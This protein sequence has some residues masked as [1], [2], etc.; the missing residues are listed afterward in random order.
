MRERVE[1]V[2]GQLQITSPE[3]G[4]TLVKVTVPINSFKN[5]ET[6]EM[7]DGHHPPDVS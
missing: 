1:S 3:S 4:G 5:S 2:E 6:E 7:P